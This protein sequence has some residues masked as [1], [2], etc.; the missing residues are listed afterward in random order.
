VQ[1]GRYRATL[2]RQVGD[3]VTPIGSAQSFAVVQLSQ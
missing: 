2:G 1:P 3:I